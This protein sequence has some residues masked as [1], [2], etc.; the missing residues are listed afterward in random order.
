MLFCE[1]KESDLIVQFSDLEIRESE[2]F[3]NTTL[4]INSLDYEIVDV[5]EFER[6]GTQIF[7]ISYIEGSESFN[8]IE[9]EASCTGEQYTA[10]MNSNKLSTL[11]WPF[12]AYMNDPWSVVISPLVKSNYYVYFNLMEEI[13]VSEEMTI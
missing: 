9:I 10:Q 4:N 11:R 1:K 2:D 8:C 6:D 5:I 7:R 13:G 12:F 3:S